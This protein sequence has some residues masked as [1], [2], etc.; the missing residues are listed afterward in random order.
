M[1][2]L[3]L[4]FTQKRREPVASALAGLEAA[5]REYS[6]HLV[7]PP[8]CVKLRLKQIDLE[9]L[10]RHGLLKYLDCFLG[11]EPEIE[12]IMCPAYAYTPPPFCS[13]TCTCPDNSVHMEDNVC[14]ERCVLV[15]DWF[16][17]VRGAKR[18]EK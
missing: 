2:V 7:S 13:R 9:W 17:L 12:V 10:D 16:V 6:Y 1:M 11:K 5:T 3:P 15:G 4:P 14:S 18:V 8:K